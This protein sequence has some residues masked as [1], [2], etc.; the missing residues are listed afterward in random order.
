MFYKIFLGLIFVGEVF[1]ITS[2]EQL[3]ASDHITVDL[4]GEKLAVNIAIEQARANRGVART[5]LRG[6]EEDK[7][8]LERSLREIEGDITTFERENGPALQNISRMDIWLGRFTGYKG[9]EVRQRLEYDEMH[10]QATELRKRI[11]T[12]KSFI[13]VKNEEIE[14]LGT[15]IDDGIERMDQIDDQL[16]ARGGEVEEARARIEQLLNGP[17]GLRALR[18]LHQYLLR[19]VRLVKQEFDLN[20]LKLQIMQNE[21]QKGINNSFLGEYI[22]RREANLLNQMCRDAAYCANSTGVVDNVTRHNI[23]RIID[24]VD[25][26]IEG[27]SGGADILR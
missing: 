5:H 3:I 15:T 13:D 16:E 4:E 6:L 9:R 17:E 24:E 21:V 8:D 11:G 19:D 26:I 23:K 18:S 27:E 2:S 7:S 1:A 22:R 12:K 14:S 10:G 20:D 25:A